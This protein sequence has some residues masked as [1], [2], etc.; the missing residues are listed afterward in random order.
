MDAYQHHTTHH[1]T[2]TTTV[3]EVSLPEGIHDSSAQRHE[4]GLRAEREHRALNRG[5]QGTEGHDSPLQAGI[6]RAIVR[7]P[8]VEA[9]LQQRVQDASDACREP[10]HGHVFVL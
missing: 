5:H 6:V 4:R 2:A 10:A 9:V 7:L 3:P 1:R 8:H